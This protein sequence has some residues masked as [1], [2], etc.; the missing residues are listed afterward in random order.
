M[1]VFDY[2]VES[3]ELPEI[4][5]VERTIVALHD[6]KHYR[7]EITRDCKHPDKQL[8]YSVDTYVEEQLQESPAR[9]RLLDGS[10]WRLVRHMPDIDRD[11]VDGALRQALL[12]LQ[13][14]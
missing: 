14:L 9:R 4:Y 1:N 2:F 12:N 8:P 6:H 3:K 13:K 10:V 7:I 5:E 11:T